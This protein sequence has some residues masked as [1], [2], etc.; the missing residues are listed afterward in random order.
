MRTS[1]GPT[2][3]AA[4]GACFALLLPDTAFAAGGDSDWSWQAQWLGAG[5]N[6]IVIVFLVVR[7]ARP[8][9]QK[10]L[11]ARKS[12]IDADIEEAERLRKEANARLD[13]LETK[14]SELDAERQAILDEYREIGESEQERIIDQ[15]ERDADRIRKEAEIWA[16]TERARAQNLIERE[17]AVMA[18]ELA[19]QSLRDEMKVMTQKKLV[20]DTI[21]QLEAKA[22]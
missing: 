15:A 13:E 14:I 1:I 6:M 2:C 10:F 7:F 17:I 11:A 3:A 18:V 22:G 5:I 16:S 4:A 8:A 12:R 9:F 19:E 20:D 21:K